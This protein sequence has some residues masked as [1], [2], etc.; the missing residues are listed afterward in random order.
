MKVRLKVPVTVI[1]VWP[2]M[3]FFQVAEMPPEPQEIALT[4]APDELALF[5][6][7]HAGHQLFQH[8]FIRLF[9]SENHLGGIF[10]SY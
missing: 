7:Q 10:C 4:A 9:A 2:G 5:A 1:S 8:V 3:S 6:L